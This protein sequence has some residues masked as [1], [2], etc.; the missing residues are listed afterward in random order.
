[1]SM[2]KPT[3]T[4]QRH[5][6]NKGSSTY[7]IAMNLNSTDSVTCHPLNAAII[8]AIIN[9]R[10][11]NYTSVEQLKVQALKAGLIR[12]KISREE[13][14]DAVIEDYFNQEL[15]EILLIRHSFL[16]NNAKHRRVLFNPTIEMLKVQYISSSLAI[17][18]Q[19]EKSADLLIHDLHHATLKRCS[20]D[21]HMELVMRR[22]HG[23]IE[24]STPT[25][26]GQL[27]ERSVKEKSAELHVYMLLLSLIHI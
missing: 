19:Y 7:Y 18:S 21:K 25:Y 12:I 22:H 20:R 11:T 1:M 27:V 14:N 3:Y 5:R 8:P 10:A 4:V 13:R 23:H 16:N 17:G 9:N 15:Y 2:L 24:Q 6:E 26:L